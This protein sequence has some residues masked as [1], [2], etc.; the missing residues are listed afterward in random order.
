MCWAWI[1]LRS[2]GVCTSINFNFRSWYKVQIRFSDNSL[3]KETIDD[4]IWLRRKKCVIYK[5]DIIFGIKHV[6]QLM[7]SKSTSG[8]RIFVDI[9][10][11]ISEEGYQ[12]PYH[13][14]KLK[15]GMTD[16]F[17]MAFCWNMRNCS[18]CFQKPIKFQS[19]GAKIFIRKFHQISWGKMLLILV[20]VFPFPVWNSGNV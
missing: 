3:Q 4:I 17:Y 6:A 15:N 20:S 10:R 2:D 7:V 11:G 16:C 19:W 14:R 8:W 1:L 13:V 18:L 12:T 9:Y 5:F